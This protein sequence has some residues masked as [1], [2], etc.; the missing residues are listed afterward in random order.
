[1]AERIWRLALMTKV[2]KTPIYIKMDAHDQLLL[3][4]EY[5]VIWALLSTKAMHGQAISLRQ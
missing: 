3:S 5:I 2:V 4:R 1:M